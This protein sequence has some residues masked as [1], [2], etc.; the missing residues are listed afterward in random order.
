MNERIEIIG[1]VKEIKYRHKVFEYNYPTC[2]FI[3]KDGTTI[4]CD[5]FIPTIRVG[6]KVKV[7]GEWSKDKDNFLEAAEVERYDQRKE[8]NSKDK[9]TK[10]FGLEQNE[11]PKTS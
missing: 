2:G 11:N 4:F 5:G 8:F 6:W 10:L 7:V 3:L 9:Q 1:I